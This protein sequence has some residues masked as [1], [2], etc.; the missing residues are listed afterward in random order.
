MSVATAEATEVAVSLAGCRRRISSRIA[1]TLVVDRAANCQS[2][3]ARLVAAPTAEVAV[4]AA[5]NLGRETS[6]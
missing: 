6:M 4:V 1:F 2:L 3:P 5:R